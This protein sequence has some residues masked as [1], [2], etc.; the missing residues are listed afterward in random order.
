M[1]DKG[2]TALFALTKD[3]GELRHCVP[4]E[5]GIPWIPFS[6]RFTCLF[7]IYLLTFPSFLI[8]EYSRI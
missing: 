3:D 7:R 4:T 8:T 2:V 5:S 6:L 1:A